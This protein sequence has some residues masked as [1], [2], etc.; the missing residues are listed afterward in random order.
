MCRTGGAHGQPFA[1]SSRGAGLL[2]SRRLTARAVC[3]GFGVPPRA[4]S[5][6]D[7]ATCRNIGEDGRA[8]LRRCLAPMAKPIE[9]AV[10]AALLMPRGAP[11]AVHRT[12]SG[13][14]AAG[15]YPFKPTPWRHIAHLPAA[16]VAASANIPPNRDRDAPGLGYPTG[17]AFIIFAAGSPNAPAFRPSRRIAS[18][19][20]GRAR[21]SMFRPR[22]PVAAGKAPARACAPAPMRWRTSAS[23]TCF[24]QAGDTAS[25]QDPCSGI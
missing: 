25:Q 1:F 5:I 14:A 17:T 24:R 4:A 11:R 8:L 19:R 3:R 22:P 18:P 20:R 23:A 12:R 15:R 2:E 9:Q 16:V 6:T 7:K 21:G 10:N 13:G